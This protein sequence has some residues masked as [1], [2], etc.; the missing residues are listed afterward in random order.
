MDS[1]ELQVHQTKVVTIYG[2]IAIKLSFFITFKGFCLKRL[3]S[4]FVDT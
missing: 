3:F 4:L 2:A 1:S